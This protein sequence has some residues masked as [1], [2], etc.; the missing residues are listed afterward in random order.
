MSGPVILSVGR[1]YYS[2]L[3]DLVTLPCSV[4]N[5][6]SLVRLWKQGSRVIFAGDMQV[7]TDSRLEVTD[8]GELVIDGFEEDDIGEYD[9]EFDTNTDIPVFIRH[10]LDLAL[11]PN[12]SIVPAS[13]QLTVTQG[14]RRTL[15][16]I[17]SGKPGPRVTWYKK[18]NSG[19]TK[20]P[21]MGPRL[22]LVN[23]SRQDEAIYTCVAEN[24]VGTPVI[25]HISVF[26]A[27]KFL[28]LSF[29]KF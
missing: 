29:I 26:V 27:C 2:S 7:R 21:N 11:P 16:C 1:Q 8:K 13:G 25:G 5:Q 3:G 22:E 4:V 9:C 23:V 6:G 14:S 17:T 12:V 24:G 18:T 19:K 10:T 20:L 28:C 15:E